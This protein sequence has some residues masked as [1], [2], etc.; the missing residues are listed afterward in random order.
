MRE[1]SAD[2]S[3]WTEGVAVG[4]ALR[5]EARFCVRHVREVDVS[6][7]WFIGLV[8]AVFALFALGLWAVYGK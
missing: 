5:R 2:G 7:G 1:L 3:R 8:A 4:C 6:D